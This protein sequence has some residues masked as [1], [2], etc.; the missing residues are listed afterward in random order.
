MTEL[1]YST[2]DLSEMMQVGKSTIKRWTEEGKL[3]CFRTPGGHRKFKASEV[4]RFL[5][6]YK[7]EVSPSYQ[8]QFS[9]HNH[10][11]QL[12]ISDNPD[13]ISDQCISN[14]IKNNHSYLEQHF[15]S[16]FLRSNGVAELFDLHLTPLLKHLNAKYLQKNIST[17]EFQ[18]AKSAFI[19]ALIT[20]T[21]NIPR[22]Q[23]NNIEMYCLSVN[24]GMNEVELK[25][26]ELLLDHI[27]FTVYN[28]GTVLTKYAAQDI[29]NQCKPEDVF[30]VLSLDDS[31]D[32]IIRQ[33]NAL[34]SGISSYGGNVYTSNFFANES[35]TRHVQ[36]GAKHLYSF[37]GIVEQFISVTNNA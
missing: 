10:T 27:G 1:Y 4:H 8:H 24:E 31:S 35:E 29:V 21:S 11:S 34:A 32:E 19:H 6:N 26:V 37:S 9:R 12:Q 5:T 15:K 17:V 30:V 13:S 33:F 28:L 2:A 7:Y 36:S 14:A 25:A 18:I 20:V 23:E 3:R 22:L 16:A